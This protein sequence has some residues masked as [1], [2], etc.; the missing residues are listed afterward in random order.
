MARFYYHVLKPFE[1]PFFYHNCYVEEGDIPDFIDKR[2]REP[3]FVR[4]TVGCCSILE[5]RKR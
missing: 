3:S 5:N 1:F 4:I 2:A